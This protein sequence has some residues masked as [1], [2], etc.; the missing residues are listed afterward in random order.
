MRIFTILFIA[1]SFPASAGYIDI[2]INQI[3]NRTIDVYL[4]WE[5]DD[6]QTSTL[7][8]YITAS[9]DLL[10]GSG[11]FL[12]GG[13]F[14]FGSTPIMNSVDRPYGLPAVTRITLEAPWF[15]VNLMPGSYQIFTSLAVEHIVDHDNCT[16][17]S[18]SSGCEWSHAGATYSQY[19]DIAYFSVPEPSTLYLL[20]VSLLG[21]IFVRREKIGHHAFLKETSNRPIDQ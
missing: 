15:N 20:L 4:S 19:T 2:D 11:N 3:N 9:F 10:D 6:G 8:Q 7:D 13:A 1:F 5:F 17:S 14:P 21:L 16:L 12:S 18:L